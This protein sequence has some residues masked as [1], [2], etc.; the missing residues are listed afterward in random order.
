VR[1]LFV[2]PHPDDIALSCGGL[3]LSLLTMD[4]EIDIVT[5]FSGSGRYERLTPY[6]QLALGFGAQDRWEPNPTEG[7]ANADAHGDPDAAV[8]TAETVPTPAEVMTLRREEDRAYARLVG[9]NI[10]HLDLP[11]AVFRDYVGDDQLLGAPRADDPAPVAELRAVVRDLRPDRFNV[12]LGVGGHVDHR[13]ARQ[14]GMA[15]VRAGDVDPGILRFYEDFPYAYNLDFTDPGQLDE[16]FRDQVDSSGPEGARVGFEPL[17]VRIADF[18]DR[19]IDGLEAYPSQLG[20][21]FGGEG[22]MASAVREQ[23]ERLGKQV[24]LDS[25][26]RYWRFAH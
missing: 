10:V 20:R 3:I 1:A 5:L 26:E 11:D 25:V 17:F 16:E 24:G 2:S 22:Q 14:A 8:T 15:L 21:L 18:L 9:V 23:A 7:G 19:K 4:H 12:P 6:Q 13:L